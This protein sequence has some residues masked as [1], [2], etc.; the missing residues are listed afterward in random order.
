MQQILRNLKDVPGVMGSFVINNEGALVEQ[1]MPAFVGTEIYPDLGRRLAIAFSTLDTAV[2][3]FDDMLLK[4]DEQWLYS[5]RLVNGILSILSAATVNLPALR[6]ATNMVAAKV[7]P[8]IPQAGL[9]AIE[10]APAAPAPVAASAPAP[11]AQPA[12][13]APRRFWRGQAVD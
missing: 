6:M 7:D 5:R 2:G 11:S 12:A 9:A 3:E 10:Q 8:L 4:F 1:E 13:P